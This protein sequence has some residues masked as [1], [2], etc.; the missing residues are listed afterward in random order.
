MLYKKHLTYILITG[1]LSFTAFQAS[2]SLVFRPKPAQDHQH[3]RRAGKVFTLTGY[4]GITVTMLTPDLV[5][6]QLDINNGSI[7]FKP[8]G[9]DNYHAIIAKRFHNNVQETAIRYVYSFG[10]PTGKSPSELT[11]FKKSELEI[12]PAPLPREHWHYKAGHKAAFSI[13]FNGKPVAD[14]KVSLSTSNAS[15]LHAKTDSLGQVEF[16]IP[17]DFTDTR[18]GDRANKPGDFL[19]HVKHTDNNQ[20][21]ATW[22]SADYEVDPAHWRNTQLGIMVAAFG[23]TIGLIITSTANRKRTGKNGVNK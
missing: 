7:K 13:H 18:A 14:S 23:F 15:I 1:M 20:Q 6:S 12:I 19:V 3:N 4:E 17:D 8:T 2:A 21:Y 10:K 22:L 5:E 16:N 9:K 11:G